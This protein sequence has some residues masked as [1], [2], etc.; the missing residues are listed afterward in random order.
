MSGLQ[1]GTASIA[2]EIAKELFDTLLVI[3]ESSLLEYDTFFVHNSSVT[4]LLV[5]I[6]TEIS[7]HNSVPPI[8]S[9]SFTR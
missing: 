9:F 7:F 3:V 2:H 1:H 4:E 5:I 6:N 8:Q